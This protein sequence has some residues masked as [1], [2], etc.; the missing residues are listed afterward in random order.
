M[1]LEDN[2]IKLITKG[3]NSKAELVHKK[4]LLGSSSEAYAFI[5]TG[6]EI[7]FNKL[8]SVNELLNIITD[9][10]N[11][12][13]ID[14]IYIDDEFINVF[15]FKNTNKQ[16]SKQDLI[17]CKK[18]LEDNLLQEP[19]SYLKLN[20]SIT[21]KL[22]EVHSSKNATKKIRLFFVRSKEYPEPAYLSEVKSAFKK[23]DS[24]LE[25]IYCDKRSLIEH[26]VKNENYVDKWI[27]NLDAAEDKFL[28]G[29]K[30]SFFRVKISDLLNLMDEAYRT[31]HNI[32]SKNIRRDMN[33]KTF[34][35]NII[36]T[37]RNE[38]ESFY[39]YHNGIT[40]TTPSLISIKKSTEITLI[41]PQVV[42]GAQTLGALY[43]NH[44]LNELDCGNAKILCKI[45]TADSSHTARICETSNTQTPVTTADLRANDD[46]QLLLD[47]IIGKFGGY[48][49]LRK[50]GEPIAKGLKNIK[51]TEFIQWF[52]S[53]EFGEPANAKNKKKY[54]FSLVPEKKSGISLYKK[55]EERL[56][57]KS[58]AD[59]K[60][61][62][63]IGL[64]VKEIIKKTGD[65]DRKSFL[66]HINMHL[67]AGL[68][69][70]RSTQ[71]SNV[72][73]I[74][75]FLAD[76]YS[77]KLDEDNSLNENKIFTKSTSA[78]VALK[79]YLK[80]K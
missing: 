15:D 33:K 23:L 70:L 24:E 12:V 19:Q 67:I 74:E 32:F 22:K 26:I 38:P 21:K 50:N 34:S 36:D 3:N 31:G 61:I 62:C 77:R 11:D 13:G 55:I 44:L 1:E 28:F 35:T 57:H 48:N 66:R 63:D 16:A 42:N 72:D 43:K 7:I 68:Y 54:I 17:I 45:V 29:P 6:L 2:A 59:L 64:T 18:N 40:I 5:I 27:L 79:T 20:E 51:L 73:M 58:A 39:I 75:S 71:K 10:A 41:N 56:Y 8:F 80:N 4:L 78:W 47:K 53:A 49:Y 46:V 60:L 52:Y 65:K 25:I 9:G 14:A 76:F 30:I 69:T 37:L